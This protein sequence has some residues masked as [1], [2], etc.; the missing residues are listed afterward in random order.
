MLTLDFESKKTTKLL[1]HKDTFNLISGLLKSNKL[2]NALML[3]N[4]G[5]GKSTIVNHLIYSYFDKEN[6]DL[7]ENALIKK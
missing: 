1:G 2:P 3:G 5:I 7:K 4:K 6:Y